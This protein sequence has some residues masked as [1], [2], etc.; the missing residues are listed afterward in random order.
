MS[1]RVGSA[2]RSASAKKAMG[3]STRKENTDEPMLVIQP[4]NWR[5]AMAPK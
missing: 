3:M 5:A 1:P 2:G 4:P